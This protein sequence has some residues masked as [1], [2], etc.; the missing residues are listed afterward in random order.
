MRE[1]LVVGNWKMNGTQE[2]VRSLVLEIIKQEQ[3]Q[4][5]KQLQSKPCN[6]VVCP[7]FVFLSQVDELRK[8]SNLQM[9]AQ[10]LDW[11]EMGAFTGE[12][13][14]EMLDSIVGHSER[15]SVYR[16]SD[17]E[18]ASKFAA[19]IKAGIKPI[20]CLGETLEERLAE[21]TEQIVA[22]QLVAV[23]EAVGIGGFGDAVIAYEPVWAIGTGET[24]TPA[25]AEALHGFIRSRLAESDLN[26]SE[27]IQILYGGSVNEKNAAELF[28]MQN[29]DGALVGGASLNAKAFMSICGFAQIALSS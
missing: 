17:N 3:E 12:I 26:I 16:E 19:C 8:D 2:S 10:N 22:R 20:L 24:A 5:Q 28:A 27:N 29:I 4:E 21:Q 1:A 6:A 13:S 14:A 15:R 11:H 18:V 7:P 25:Q 23:L 9:G